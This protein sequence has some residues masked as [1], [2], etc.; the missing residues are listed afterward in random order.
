M[1][2]RYV[3]LYDSDCGFCVWALSKLL[4][5]DRRA[6]L[7]PVALQD[8]E[9]DRLLGPIVPEEKMGSWHLVAP[10]GEVRSAGSGIAPL[11]R[12]LPGGAAL[13]PAFAS[14]RFSNAA[15]YAVAG[16]RST[17]GKLVTAG[18]RRRA[19]ARVTART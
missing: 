12:L 16:R 5:W 8:P 2:E 1:S 13:A 18:A 7:R 10:D 11:L 17:W 3:L 4:V 15:Y 14:A 6:R 9:A 19:R